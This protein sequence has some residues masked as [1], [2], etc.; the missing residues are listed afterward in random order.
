MSEKSVDVVSFL[1]LCRSRFDLR[2]GLRLV[3]PTNDWPVT[4]TDP[5]A[6]ITSPRPTAV[7]VNGGTECVDPVADDDADSAKVAVENAE[8][9]MYELEKAD[10]VEEIVLKEAEVSEV[11]DL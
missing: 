4:T 7:V 3:T 11:V 8:D 2:T 9:V 6:P 10:K 5:V 1:M